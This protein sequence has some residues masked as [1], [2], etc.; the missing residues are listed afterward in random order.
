YSSELA[1]Q[2][3]NLYEQAQAARK[4]VDADDA[5]VSAKS[6]EEANAASDL[7]AIVGFVLDAHETSTGQNT[8]HNWETDWGSYDRTY[9]QDKR[10]VIA[11]HDVRR[12]SAICQ[13]DVYFVG[14]A[15]ADEHLYI[16]GHR[17][18]RLTVT[19]GIEARTEI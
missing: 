17:P 10:I 5:L 4:Q 1:T 12:N 8:D 14:K 3:R 18:I 16:Y 7:R 15:L 9:S 19:E 2:Q 13:I 6:A 11:V